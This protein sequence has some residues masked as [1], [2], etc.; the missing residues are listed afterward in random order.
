MAIGLAEILSTGIIGLIVLPPKT[1]PR[2]LRLLAKI[3]T[4]SRQ[5]CQILQFQ[6]H[7]I[8]EQLETLEHSHNQ[9]HPKPH[10]NQLEKRDKH[11]D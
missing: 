1:W 9:F 6:Y 10:S 2:A 5:Y 3:F 8:A 7:K 11:G 4:K